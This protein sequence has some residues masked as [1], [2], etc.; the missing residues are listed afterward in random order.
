MRSNSKDRSGILL[1]CHSEL[2]EG[3]DN[4]KDITDSLFAAQ[5]IFINL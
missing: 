1:N 3:L 5:D 4:L 2:V